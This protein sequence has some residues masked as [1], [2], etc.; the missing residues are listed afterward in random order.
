MT[1]NMMSML[2]FESDT[3]LSQSRD[4]SLLSFQRVVKREYGQ[5]DEDN[6]F[7]MATGETFPYGRVVVTHIF[8][9]KW[10]KFLRLFTSSTKMDDASNSLMLYRPVAWAFN[11]GKLCINVDSVG[12]M[13]FHLFDGSLRDINL[14]SKARSLEIPPRLADEVVGGE[15]KL[16]LTFGGISALTFGPDALT[17]GDLDG[18]EVH[19]PVGSKMR[20]SKR[21]LALHGYAAW[22]KA[23][24]LDPDIE[25]PIPQFNFLA[26][27]TNGTKG[28][29]PTLL[30]EQ[31]RMG[32]HATPPVSSNHINLLDMQ[33]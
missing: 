20:P 15:T 24:S 14:A 3:S 32:V 33:R 5:F 7:D 17:F 6:L 12:R 1:A 30:V 28:Q 23:Q 13:S 8:Q 27:E 25:C 18:Q 10:Q 31:W 4:E 21:L 22:L 11:R 16:D 9:R 29:D 26:E 19:F 2:D